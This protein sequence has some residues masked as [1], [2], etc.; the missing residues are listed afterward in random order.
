MIQQIQPNFRYMRQFIFYLAIL[1][2]SCY[3]ENGKEVKPGVYARVGSIE[4]KREELFPFN[5]KTPDKE[6]LNGAIKNWIDQTV[7]LS[8]AKKK[9]FENDVVLLRKRDSYYKN[10]IV[11][12]FVE[13]F[14]SS[15][16]S[17][18]NEDVRL[19]YKRNKGEFL[20]GF[21]EVKI[22]QYVVN[23]KKIANRLIVSFNSK[24][25]VDLSKFDIESI[26]AEVVRRGTLSKKIDDELFIKKKGVV[27]PVF[28]GKEISVL[29]VLNRYNKGSTKGLSEVYDEIYQRVFK[30]KSLEAKVSLLDSLKRTVNISISP[31]YQ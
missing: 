11:D 28:L 13:S 4:L 25:G 27:G 6:A 18:S 1:S 17:V 26:R 31:E 15:R 24:K 9:G 16:V 2:F 7:L 12:S 22:E 23:S 21:D 19:Y 20:R 3:K 29:K 10:L 30:I 5:K 8:E 14:I